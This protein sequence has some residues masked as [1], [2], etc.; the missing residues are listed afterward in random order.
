MGGLCN[1]DVAKIYM[2]FRNDI[3]GQGELRDTIAKV[4][5]IMFFVRG[6]LNNLSNMSDL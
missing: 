3:G 5:T 6:W 2:R 1:A 4:E